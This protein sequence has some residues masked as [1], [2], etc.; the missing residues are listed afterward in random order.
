MS[1]VEVFSDYVTDRAWM[2]GGVSRELNLVKDILKNYPQ[3]VDVPVNRD[4]PTQRFFI[5]P[6]VAFGMYICQRSLYNDLIEENQQ[7]LALDM[8]QKLC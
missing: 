7:M 3:G 6:R 2:L 1:Q 5:S 4:E 8:M